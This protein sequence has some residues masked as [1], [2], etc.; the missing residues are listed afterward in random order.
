[1]RSFR[2]TRLYFILSVLFALSCLGLSILGALKV[3]SL[4][5]DES[6]FN[7]RIVEVD[8]ALENLT[9][10][11]LADITGRMCGGRNLVTLDV[12][13]LLEELMSLPWVSKV[14]AV[15]R[16]PHT[17]VLSVVEHVPA[18]YW[19]DNGLFDAATRSVFYPKALPRL[20]LVRLSA[21]AD[22]EA[23]SLY[24]AAALCL[25]ILQ[26]TPLV[27]VEAELDRAHV[28]SLTLREGTVLILG[29]IDAQGA[30]RK[31]IADRLQRFA[32]SFNQLGSNL[33]QIEYADLRYDSG[34]AVRFRS[35][36]E[37]NHGE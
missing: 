27:M 2:R 3:R 34:F 28:L 31:I 32:R 14:K 23:A 37:S 33:N 5:Y 22:D 36:D 13:P 12:D 15:K 25:K 16:L 20:P 24:D 7:L 6:S 35:Q 11:E 8:G 9:V 26:G 29:R 21:P 10:K 17:L 4:L 19:N 18:A 30:W 1:M